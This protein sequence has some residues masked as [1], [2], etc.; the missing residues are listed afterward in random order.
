MICPDVMLIL[1]GKFLYRP[2][3]PLPGG[4]VLT[5]A[6]SSVIGKHYGALCANKGCFLD[7]I[8][9]TVYSFKQINVPINQQ[10]DT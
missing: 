2:M 5:L 8:F 6:L 4:W 7:L 1:G 10:S 9:E 3:F